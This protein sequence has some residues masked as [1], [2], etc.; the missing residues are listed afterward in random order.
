MQVWNWRW[1][2]NSFFKSIVAISR[3]F[4]S[5]AAVPDVQILIKGLRDM[6]G[7]EK[8]RKDRK[9]K[10]KSGSNGVPSL[11]LPEPSPPFH[12][13]FAVFSYSIFSAPSVLSERLSRLFKTHSTLPPRVVVRPGY[14]VQNKRCFS[15]WP[16]SPLR[17]VRQNPI[18]INHNTVV[19]YNAADIANGGVHNKKLYPMSG[20]LLGNVIGDVRKQLMDPDNMDFRPKQ[21]S[22]YI[23]DDVGPCNY[24]ESKTKYWIPGRIQYK[25]A[26]GCFCLIS[27]G[28]IYCYAVST[29]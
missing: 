20:K 23:Q 8:R 25:V 27:C 10:N 29:R 3:P 12:P 14:L 7:G 5:L 6:K 13:P 21:G 1:N 9:K 4:L 17:Y 28:F 18:A 26:G 19:E 16:Y 2:S 11:S 24:E 15:S 22:S